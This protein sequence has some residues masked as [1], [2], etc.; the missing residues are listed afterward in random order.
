[1]VAAGTPPVKEWFSPGGGQFAW[2]KAK[3]RPQAVSRPAVNSLGD[4]YIAD[5]GS[6][7]PPDII[8]AA[9]LTAWINADALLSR[10]FAEIDAAAPANGLG[11][12]ERASRI[13]ALDEERLALERQEEAL[14]ERAEAEGVLIERR[15]DADPR[16]A[17]M[18]EVV[19]V[20]HERVAA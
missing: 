20:E 15:P 19:E 5:G 3:L 18:I 14:I 1:L 9:A 6:A 13:G 16:A 2:P 8:D 10:L 4:R 12:D 17:L 7:S 11:D